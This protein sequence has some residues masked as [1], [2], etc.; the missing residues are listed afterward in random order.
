MRVPM[1]RG[2]CNIRDAGR[3]VIVR[4]NRTRR[5]CIEAQQH[6]EQASA[7]LTRLRGDV[8]TTAG[9]TRHTRDPPRS[10]ARRREAYI[11]MFASISEIDLRCR[12]DDGDVGRVALEDERLL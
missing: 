8:L 6:F 12:P 5:R 1:L 11:A 2:V 4:A 9:R 7:G 10:A 3:S